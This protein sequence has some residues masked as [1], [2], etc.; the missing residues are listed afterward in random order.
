MAG[1]LSSRHL[2]FGTV[3]SGGQGRRRLAPGP[4]PRAA[5][6]S[7]RLAASMASTGRAHPLP[8]ASTVA[9]SWTLAERVIHRRIARAREGF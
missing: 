6:R 8:A 9:P 2:L 3:R 5:T 4:D 1:R 7:S